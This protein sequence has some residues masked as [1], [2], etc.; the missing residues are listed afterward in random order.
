MGVSTSQILRVL[1]ANLKVVP[2]LLAAVQ[3]IASVDGIGA[4]IDEVK[5]LLDVLKPV[6][7]QLEPLMAEGNFGFA[8]PESIVTDGEC[9]AQLADAGLD[10]DTILAYLPQIKQ[11]IDL[12]FLILSRG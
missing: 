4:K 11:I 1:L 10:Y 2:E 8:E 6:L 12:I 5:K 7:E 3:A 9:S